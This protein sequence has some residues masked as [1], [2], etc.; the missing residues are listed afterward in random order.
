MIHVESLTKR[1]GKLTALD[2][3]SIDVYRGETIA[4]LGPNGSG[5][6]TFLKVIVGLVIPERGMVEINGTDAIK[7]Q[8]KTKRVIS[9]LPQRVFL[10]AE[11]SAEEVLRYYARLRRAD[12]S[13]IS[14]LLSLSGIKGYSKKRVGQFSGGMLQRLALAVIRLGDSE[15]YLLDEPTVNLDLEG[16]A[17]FKEFVRILKQAGKTII[18][19]TH[20]LTEAELFADRIAFLKSGR[21]IALEDSVSIRRLSDNV[22]RMMLVVEGSAENAISVLKEFG[23]RHY[24]FVGDV[25]K[26]VSSPDSRPQIIDRLQRVG[27][28]VIRFWTEEPSLEYVYEQL[29]HNEERK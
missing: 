28:R 16:L 1:Y 2:D 11:L 24:E 18:I 7:Y 10:P 9:Y 8:L 12:E 22:A 17:V 14:D 6:S 27:V 3:V 20:T 23:V 5:K 21:L 4:L 26:T 19:A 29:I 15:I 25:I 13:T